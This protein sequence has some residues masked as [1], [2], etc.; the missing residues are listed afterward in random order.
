MPYNVSLKPTIIYTDHFMNRSIAGALHKSKKFLKPCHVTKFLNYNLPIISYGYLRGT[1]ELYKKSNDFWYLDHGYFKQSTR[2]F[3]NGRVIINDLNGY[4]RIVHND[5]WHSGEKIF[6]SFRFDKLNLNFINQN[7]KGEYIIVSEPTN[8]AII[9]YGLENWTNETIEEIKKY[10]DRKI[11]IHNRNSKTPLKELITDAFAFVSDHS[12]AGFLSILQGVPA[13]F[14]NKTLRNIG[15]IKNI[16]NHVINFNILYNLSYGQWTIEE[17]KSGEA[18]EF[19][20][21]ELF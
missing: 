16:E 9:Y 1:G 11:I 18:W 12:S 20:S 6:D 5:F 17:I 19:V 15:N 10:S 13:F 2:E 3:V 7:F 8:D 21:K 4:F 14:T